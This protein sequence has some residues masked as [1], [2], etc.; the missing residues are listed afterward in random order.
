MALLE[1]NWRPTRRDLRN[2]GMAA[3]VLLPIL[4][5]L[6]YWLKGLGTRWILCLCGAGLLIYLLS[7]IRPPLAKPIYLALMLLALPIGYTLGF[8]LLAIIYFLVLTPIALIFKLARR[9]PLCRKF[10]SHIPS[11][12][13]PR[14]SAATVKRYFQQF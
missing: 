7:L 5:L 9:D 1:I 6:L 14:Q 3:L 2:F 8:L 13:T 10:D 12:W 11:Y 4:A